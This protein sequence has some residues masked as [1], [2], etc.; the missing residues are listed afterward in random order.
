VNRTAAL[1]AALQRFV[2]ELQRWGSR[3]NLVGSTEPGE[4]A[5]HIED[6]LSGAAVFSRGTT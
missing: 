5:R 3:M 4:I 1:E 6:S 2:A